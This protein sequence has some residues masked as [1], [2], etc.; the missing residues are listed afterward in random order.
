[1]SR[2]PP[3]SPVP[4]GPLTPQERAGATYVQR[5][6]ADVLRYDAGGYQPDPDR[7][8]VALRDLSACRALWCGLTGDPADD[9]VLDADRLNLLVLSL[10]AIRRAALPS[11]NL[12]VLQEAVG[13]VVGEVSRRLG[14][15][16]DRVAVTQTAVSVAREKFPEW[17]ADTTS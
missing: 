16:P 8:A 9:E 14:P 15:K 11:V 17:F 4:R 10:R 2:H 13:A 1:M 3:R 7:Y 5:V 12:V 6:L